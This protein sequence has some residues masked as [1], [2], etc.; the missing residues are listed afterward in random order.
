MAIGEIKS[1]HLNE[2]ISLKMPPDAIREVLEGVLLMMGHSDMSWTGMRKFLSNKGIK[3]K[4]ISF[5]AR[6]LINKTK[7]I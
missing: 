6:N 1:S 2:L 3:D 7:V 4:I 5:D